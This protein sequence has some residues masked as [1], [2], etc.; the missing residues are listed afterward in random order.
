[1][2]EGTM[3]AET[4]FIKGAYTFASMGVMAPMAAIFM[5]FINLSVFQPSDPAFVRDIYMI[6]AF[7]LV[8]AGVNIIFIFL[9]SRVFNPDVAHNFLVQLLGFLL[10]GG[11]GGGILAFALFETDIT[12]IL[13]GVLGG[14]IAAALIGFMVPKTLSKRLTATLTGPTI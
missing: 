3:R 9:G 5:K 2:G 6:G 10:S 8:I 11:L 14:V 12:K 4:G 7:A 13:Q 1:M